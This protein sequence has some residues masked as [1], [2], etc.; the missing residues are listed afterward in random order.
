MGIIRL[1]QCDGVT[2]KS[3]VYWAKTTN[4]ESMERSNSSSHHYICQYFLTTTDYDI[5]N[6]PITSYGKC[7]FACASVNNDSW[8]EFKQNRWK[9]IEEEA[10]SVS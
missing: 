3:I 8:Y 9:P 2:D 6:A 1:Y 5:A 10:P 4:K 7:N